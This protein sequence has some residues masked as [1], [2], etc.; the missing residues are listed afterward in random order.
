VTDELFPV[1]PSKPKAQPPATEDEC[2]I[3]LPVRNQVEAVFSDLDGLIPLDHQVRVVWGY[4][5]R[6]DLA[7]LYGRIKAVEGRPGRAAIDPRIL[8]ALW[9]YATLDGVG[10]ARALAK[11]C[12]DSHPYRWI[13]GGVSVN[14]HTLADF[15]VENG[16]V[17][18]E[19]LIDSVTSLR[20]A[21]AV[22]LNR[23]A[24][25]GMRVRAN[26]GSGSF[27]GKKTLERF[28]KEAQEQVEALRRELDENPAASDDQIKSARERAARERQERVAAALKQYDDVKKKKKHHKEKA[29][30]STTDPDARWMRMGDG[31]SRPAYNVQISTETG[32]QLIVGVKVINSGSDSDQLEPAVMRIQEQHGV[33][34]KEFLVDGGYV[35]REAF[36]TLAEPPNNCTVYAPVPAP[37]KKNRPKDQPFKT[38]TPRVTEWRKRM[39]TAEAKKIYK[40]RAA[41]AECVNAL[42]RN[43][44][45][46]QFPVRGLKK[47][48]AVAILFALAHNLMRLESLKNSV[49]A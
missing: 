30:V 37:N 43:R 33:V 26:A 44:G 13:C 10:S 24:H 36:E 35:K 32:T 46:Q 34:P 25:D 29:R 14:Y 40:E 4:V 2:R 16:N 42:A 47:V 48:R 1:G 38:E 12:E 15:R 41:T 27:R 6:A 39:K 11:L 31:G 8:L 49:A 18:E 17:L 22:T 19:L 20:A 45:L 9:L 28:Q 7:E 3:A 21:G 23:V 5:E